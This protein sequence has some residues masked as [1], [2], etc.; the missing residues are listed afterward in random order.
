MRK[1]L[2]FAF[3]VFATSFLFTSCIQE[4][5]PS[6]ECDILAVKATWL[7]ENKE[8]LSGKPMI[9]NNAVR[10]YVNEETNVETL[11]TLDPEFELTPGAHIEK[12]DRIKM[13]GERGVYLFYKTTSE[14]GKWSKEYEV[15]FTK[16]TVIDTEATFSF[17]HFAIEKKYYV[18]H[19]EDNKGTKL[20]W[21]ASGNAG[22]SMSGQGKTPAD[23]PTS[24]DSAGIKGYGVKL[25]TRSTGTF[26]KMMKMPIAAGNIFIGEFLT[27]NATKAP[28]EATRF[29]FTIAPSKPVSLTGYYKY[30][31]GE[32]FTNKAMEEI[33]DRRDTCA[34]YSVLY[35]IDP[36]NVVTLDGSNVLSSERIVLVAQ[37]ETPGEESEWT[38]FEIAYKEANGNTFDYKKLENGEYAIT[39]V[40]SSS[41][42]GAYFEGAVG[43]TLC[44]DEVKINWE[45]R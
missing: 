22:F 13:N 29:G 11:K 21:W 38:E 4:E 25:T 6:A 30:T 16:Q 1:T 17:E 14:D 18:W 10:F 41:K 15:S 8:I 23:F 37:L 45:N 27:A 39:V 5:A 43:S 26:G 28:L 19:E 3:I 7:E 35:E 42:D 36:N 24:V 31:P 20:S 12:L 9:S 2:F 33:T 40:A 32:V 44:I 34:I